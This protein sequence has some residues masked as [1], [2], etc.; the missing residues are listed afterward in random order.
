MKIFALLLFVSLTSDIYGATDFHCIYSDISP[1]QV[2]IFDKAITDDASPA[3]LTATNQ[4]LPPSNFWFTGGPNEHEEL[5]CYFSH[6][7]G[8]KVST[9]KQGGPVLEGYVQ[10]VAPHGQSIAFWDACYTANRYYATDLMYR[11]VNGFNRPNSWVEVYDTRS[12]VMI[13]K[14]SSK[15][16]VCGYGLTDLN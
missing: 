7:S 1:N 13:F 4:T 8:F 11:W 12:G 9:T 5:D 10:A 15:P 3:L 6:N 2:L 14:G 16:F